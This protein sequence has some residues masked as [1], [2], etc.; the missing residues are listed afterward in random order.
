MLAVSLFLLAFDWRGFGKGRVTALIEVKKAFEFKSLMEHDIFEKF[1]CEWIKRKT[2]ILRNKK[3]IV[4]RSFGTNVSDISELTKLDPK[5]LSPETCFKAP[6]Y[7]PP[8]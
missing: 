3:I 7:Y 1:L 2:E 5:Q 6:I 4:T 8:V